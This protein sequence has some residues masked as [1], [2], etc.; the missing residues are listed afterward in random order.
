[1]FAL[2][3]AGD[4][5]ARQG[6]G[7]IVGRV[8]SSRNAEPLVNAEVSIPSLNLGALTD[9]DGRYLIAGVPPGTHD[10]VVRLIGYGTK[11][12]TGVAVDAGAVVPLDI[13]LAPEAIQF[14]ALTVTASRERGSATSL[15]TDRLGAALVVDAIGADQIARSPDGDAAAALA[16]V[17]GVSVVDG[18]YVYV[19]GLGER[20]G[21][22][23]L[24]G[25]PLPSPEPDRKVV[26]LDIIPTGLLESVVTAK[27][28]SPDQP[29]DHA[30]GLVQLRT[31]QFVGARSFK[32][33]AS[34]G[35][36]TAATWKDGLGYAGG[37]YDFLAF[38]DGARDLPAAVPADRSLDGLASADLE[39]IGKAFIGTWG[40]RREP[41]P[42]DQSF[43]LAFGDQIEL[44]GLALGFLGS[45]TQSSGYTRYADAIE[46]VYSANDVEV[47]YLGE[48]T[49]QA[50][51]LGAL[52]NLG[53]RITPTHRITLAAVYNRFADDEARIFDGWNL[54][55][56]ADVRNYRIRYL[57]QTL[58]NVQL[59]GD[60]V[61]DGLGD[62]GLRWRGAYAAAGRYEPNTR[63]MLYRKAPDGRFLWENFIQSGSVFHQDLTEDGVSGG[64]DLE[65]PIRLRSLP[66][67]LSLGAAIDLRDRAAYTRRFRFLQRGAVAEEVRERSPDLIFSDETIRAVD[68]FLIDE[69]TFDTDNYDAGQEVLAAYV[70][71]DTEILPRLRLA[72]G[73]R[74]ERAEQTV[75]P[76]VLPGSGLIAPE[77]ANTE[78]TDI[79]PALN[80]TYRLGDAMNLRLGVSR[81]LARP[82]L[83]EL[84]PFHFADYAGG[85]LT[86][87]NTLLRRA[88][89]RNHDLRWEWSPGPGRVL[90]LSTFHKRFTDPIEVLV[91]P[92]TELKK[93]WV[94]AGRATN[95][96]VELELRTGLEFLAPALESLAINANVTLVRSEVETGGVV[97][98]WDAGQELRIELP[99]RERPLQGQSPYVVNLGLSY[100]QPTLGTTATLLYN[101]FGR[102]IDS[103]GSAVL[104]DV[105]E[106]ARDRLDFV[107]EQPLPYGLSIKVTASRLLGSEVRFTQD[108]RT[109]RTYDA[110]RTL[111]VSASWS[112]GNR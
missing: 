14:E 110:G 86:L 68:G 9:L 106:E 98:A 105:Y 102:R 100:V 21:S 55:A 1:M 3:A 103:V 81:T 24:N 39:R 35:F 48:T 32:V 63:E 92:S 6:T 22:T 46:R 36:N 61:F 70:M 12:L 64:V 50:A 20:Y 77:G 83:R 17:P 53:L 2:G 33:S 104:A 62:V 45:L 82:H 96:G 91:L 19:R 38:D 95:Y 56:N 10:I 89:I 73:A 13:A 42:L 27:T 84:A 41:L 15:L 16:R 51:T 57:S 112:P 99:A 108:G 8:F 80:L 7:R 76:R 11:T 37:K 97:R 78:D 26:P 88:T 23:T 30:G 107:A 109:V 5:T 69:S 58:L 54:D 34:V 25:A 66:A 71:I 4:A 74:I 111:S 31:R 93:T 79:L 59:S 85:Y 29:G 75:T 52:A 49:T 87:G 90:S 18:K 94:N 43:G 60:H 72:G 47:D 40:P 28:Y 67:S 44:G 101:R 65:L